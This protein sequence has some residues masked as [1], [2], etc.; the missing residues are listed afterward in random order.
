MLSES[1]EQHCAA[2]EAEGCRRDGC[3]V[4]FFSKSLGRRASPTSNVIDNFSRRGT[5]YQHD[6]VFMFSFAATGGL[7]DSRWRKQS[8]EK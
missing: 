2:G 5:R 1:R 8:K 3:S 6:V 4:C 7:G